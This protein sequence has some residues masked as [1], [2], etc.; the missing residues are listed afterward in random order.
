MPPGPFK[1]NYIFYIFIWGFPPPPHILNQVF[2]YLKKYFLSP[3]PFFWISLRHLCS[4]LNLSNNIHVHWF[5]GR[6]CLIG[7]ETSRGL[8]C[9]S[10]TNKF[11]IHV[12]WFRDRKTNRG[13][14]CVP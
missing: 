7:G 11:N 12:H 14:D 10:L 3:P 5:S 13:L 8:D 1:K 6:K 2:K 4:I 9:V